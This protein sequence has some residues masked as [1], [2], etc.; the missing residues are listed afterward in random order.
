MKEILLELKKKILGS[1]KNRFLK[2][3]ILEPLS[4]IIENSIYFSNSE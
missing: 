1:N 4:P 2:N 3:S